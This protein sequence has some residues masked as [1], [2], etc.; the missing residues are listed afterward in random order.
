MNS[1]S[2]RF[3]SLRLGALRLKKHL[4]FAE[5]EGLPKRKAAKPQRREAM[6]ETPFGIWY[7]R[8][9]VSCPTPRGPYEESC[10]AVCSNLCYSF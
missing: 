8:G 2:R 1:R 7:R 9:P 3:A 4:K 6:V 5:I 10:A